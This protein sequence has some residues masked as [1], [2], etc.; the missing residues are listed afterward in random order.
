M[1]SVLY[2]KKKFFQ[3]LKMVQLSVE[4]GWLTNSTFI[5]VILKKCNK[6]KSN[7]LFVHRLQ[8]DDSA[9]ICF[10]VVQGISKYK[11]LLRMVDVLRKMSCL[12]LNVMTN[13]LE[14]FF[15]EQVRF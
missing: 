13:M 9:K 2:L 5:F 11:E 15:Y 1:E 6:A 7:H 12:S 4:W 3:I 8:I 10:F 14:N